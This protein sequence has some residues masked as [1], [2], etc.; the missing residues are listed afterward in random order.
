V[1]L[2]SHLKIDGVAFASLLHHFRPDLI[3]LKQ[4]SNDSVKNLNL[5]F[6]A[7]EKAG[8]PKLLDAEDIAVCPERLS[9]T[10]YLIK[11]YETFGSKK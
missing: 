2:N 9:I 1:S 3:N 8:I 10:T 6:S 11:F 4:L 7:A 5:A